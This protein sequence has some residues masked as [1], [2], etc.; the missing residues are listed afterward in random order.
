MVKKE[1]LK[2][3]NQVK[4]TFVLPLNADGRKVSVVG[5]FNRWDPTA[6]PLVKRNNGTMSS[7]VTLASGQKVRFRYFA[8]DGEWFNDEQADAYEASVH[9][10]DNC[11]AVV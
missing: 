10:S 7:S 6:N 8:A 3:T 4:L 9:G 11:V 5:D 2:R 1:S